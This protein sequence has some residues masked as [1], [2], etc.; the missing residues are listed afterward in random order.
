MKV[1]RLLFF[2]LVL[3]ALILQACGSAESA[4][5]TGVAQTLQIAELQT[6]AAGGGSGGE[7]VPSATTGPGEPSNTP[8]PSETP[9]I[10]LTPTSSIP[11]VSVAENTNCRTGPS[12]N[13]GFVTLITTGQQLEVLKVFNSANYVVIRNPNGSGDCW[14]WLQ[15]A[16]PVDFAQYNLPLAT[17]PPTPTATATA[18]ATYIWEGDWTASVEGGGI[19]TM[20]LTESGNTISGSYNCPGAGY[21]GTVSGTLSANRR[22]VNGTWDTGVTGPFTWQRKTVNTNQ[23]IGNWD[24][25]NYWCGAR[26][27]ASQ[28]DPCLGP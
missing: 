8:Q 22:T 18:T 23:F 13:Y 15:Y 25:T 5:Q 17:Q 3:S 6:A 24:G 26:A 2:L 7:E 14:L 4:I 19:C 9:T 1:R 10:T 16:T 27:G 28:P 11:Y 21:G 12:S 20:T